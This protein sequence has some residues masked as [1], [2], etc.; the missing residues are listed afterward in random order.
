V[1]PG[2]DH[3]RTIQARCSGRVVC[4]A[5]LPSRAGNLAAWTVRLR[6]RLALPVQL[7]G[8]PALQI[9]DSSWEVRAIGFS[10]QMKG[11][12]QTLAGKQFY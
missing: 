10:P 9:L 11:Q 8:R 3:K 12:E 1:L 2:R 7:V 4:R 5:G 6:S